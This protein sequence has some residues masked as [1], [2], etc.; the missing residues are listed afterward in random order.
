MSKSKANT[1]LQRPCRRAYET[2]ERRGKRDT[3]GRTGVRDMRGDSKGGRG[4]I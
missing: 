1:L 4:S 3:N 2:V